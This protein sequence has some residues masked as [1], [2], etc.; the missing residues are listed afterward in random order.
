MLSVYTHIPSY[1][2]VT[3]LQILHPLYMYTYSYITLPTMCLV[4]QVIGKLLLSHDEFI[5]QIYICIT[6]HLSQINNS[7]VVIDP[8]EIVINYLSMSITTACLLSHLYNIIIIVP[9]NMLIALWCRFSWPSSLK[10][11]KFSLTMCNTI[12]MNNII[13]GSTLNCSCHNCLTILA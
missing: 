11:Q 3:V 7:I 5:Y 13:R 12:A 9:N 2:N 4:V 10:S 1:M 6:S 8:P